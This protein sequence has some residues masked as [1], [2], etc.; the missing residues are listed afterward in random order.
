[1]P[2]LIVLLIILAAQLMPVD[3]AALSDLPAGLMVGFIVGLLTSWGWVYAVGWNGRV[4]AQRVA[5][6]EK[7]EDAAR[8]ARRPLPLLGA[9]LAMLVVVV[10][11]AALGNL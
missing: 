6:V 10:L 4:E 1:M 11:A 5:D 3:P 9:V 7:A 2:W 8:K